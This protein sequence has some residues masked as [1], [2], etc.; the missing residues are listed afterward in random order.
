[1]S[2]KILTLIAFMFFTNII[3]SQDKTN[4]EKASEMT[5]QMQTQIGF[6]DETYA[7]VY[8]ENLNFVT[9]TQELKQSDATK[10]EKF[11]SLK[12]YDE[13]RDKALKEILTEEEFKLFIENKS[14]NRQS[15]KERLK[16]SRE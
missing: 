14:K 11:K 12:K 3:F 10:I 1:M 15:F 16:A 5:K 2:Y 4:E 6:N 7:K 13:T 9:N 8:E